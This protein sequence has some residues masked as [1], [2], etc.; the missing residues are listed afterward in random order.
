DG[1]VLRPA[2][3]R[4]LVV[5]IDTL[6]EAVHFP[7]DLAAADLAYRAVAVNVSDIAA[8]GARPR[9]M[10]L[11]LTLRDVDT[12]W[13]DGFAEGLNSAAADYRLEL[14]GGDTTRGNEIVISVQITGDVQR[15]RFIRRSGARA[16]EGIYVTGT[17]GDAAAGL[18]MLARGPGDGDDVAYLQRRFRRPQARADFAQAVA[19]RL[20]AAID[21]SDGLYADIAKLLTAS[22]VGG[23]LE[24][25]RLPLSAALLATVGRARAVELALGGGDD[26]ELA[27]TAPAQNAEA[28]LAIAKEQGLAVTRIGDVLAGEAL[29]CTEHGRPV[30]YRDAG[31]RHFGRPD[32]P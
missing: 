14:V 26:Y 8:M 29:R 11:A 24:L 2:E 32:G 15:G 25:E 13:L 3:G 19:D 5:V 10:T 22:G 20:S 6:V 12:E 30:E 9:W 27:F 16:G 21:L 7:V 31:Y 1:A 23:R 18:S 28:I 17:P 4:D